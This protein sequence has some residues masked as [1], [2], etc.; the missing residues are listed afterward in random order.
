MDTTTLYLAQLIGPAA[1][2]MGISMLMHKKQFGE[3]MK[4]LDK[5]QLSLLL[6]AVVE[7]VAG[8][9]LLLSHHLWGSTAE[10]MVTLL[11][12]GMLL[13]GLCIF[14]G[15]KAF[16]KDCVKLI[17]KDMYQYITLVGIS[18][19]LYGGYL[20]YLGYFM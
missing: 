11:G 13:D 1:T 2:L 8:T 5:S 17:T 10:V 18:S 19:L 14:I 3:L 12:Y 16:L 9:A 4:N 15:G 7:T 20:S 6:D